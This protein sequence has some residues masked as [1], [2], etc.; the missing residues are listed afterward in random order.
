MRKF[1][2]YQLALMGAF[3]LSACNGKSADGSKT[4]TA[5]D[6]IGHASNLTE[7]NITVGDLTF[8][9]TLNG[10]DKFTTVLDSGSLKIK[11]TE[12]YD[13]FCDPNDGKLSNNTLPLLLKKVDNTKPFTLMAK[14]TPE[15]TEE[16]LYNAANLMVYANDTLF[17][18]FCFEQDERGNHRIVTVRTQGTSDDNNHDVVSESSVYMKISSDTHTIASYYSTDKKEWHMVRLY[19]NNYPTIIYVGIA[20]QCPKKGECTS[21]FENLSLNQDNVSDFRMG[22]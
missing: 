16:G 20:S 11:C 15:F 10:A 19:K 14:V 17:Q 22:E 8:D 4:A 18:K 3:L 6:S 13:F 21:L 9:Y 2:F 7:C 12:G 5:T 1:H